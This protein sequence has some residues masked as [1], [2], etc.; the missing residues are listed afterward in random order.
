MWLDGRQFLCDRFICTCVC[1]YSRIVRWNWWLRLLMCLLCLKFKLNAGSVVDCDW[2]DQVGCYGDRSETACFKWNLCS[3]YVHANNQ[4]FPLLKSELSGM[5][6]WIWLCNHR[7]Y[8]SPDHVNVPGTFLFSLYRNYQISLLWNL[9]VFLS[10]HILPV[11]ENMESIKIQ[12]HICLYIHLHWPKPF[13][14]TLFKWL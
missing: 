4:V 2:L 7:R 14:E 3:F 13:V 5:A 10:L 12:T 1:K 11:G 9:K 6:M 8:N